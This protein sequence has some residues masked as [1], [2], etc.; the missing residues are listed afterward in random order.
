M[1]HGWTTHD[2]QVSSISPARCSVGLHRRRRFC[3]PS[4]VTSAG[5]V[6]L[7][8]RQT[9]PGFHDSTGSDPHRERTSRHQR[10]GRGAADRAPAA[11]PCDPRSRAAHRVRG[12][13][14][15]RRR[16]A[17][18]SRSDPAG[19]GSLPH[20][21][22]RSDQANR[23][24]LH[25]ERLYRRRD[26]DRDSRGGAVSHGR[27]PYPRDSRIRGC[28]TRSAA[29]ARASHKTSARSQ[30]R[31]RVQPVRSSERPP[32]TQPARH[33]RDH[34][35]TAADRGAGPGYRHLGCQGAEDR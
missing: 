8:C 15:D 6:E 35:S 14:C 2:P 7:H 29:H 22:G 5:L 23:G 24:P 1:P 16:R 32:A 21:I 17:A 19:T 33:L 18:R 10:T 20:P 12:Q 25:R 30:G 31:G 4:S 9:T 34:R 13:L 11:D 28:D 26:T 3:W 27:F